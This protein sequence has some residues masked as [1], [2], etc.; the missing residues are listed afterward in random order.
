VAPCAI[1]KSALAPIAD[2]T[3]P[4]TQVRKVP[5]NR[6]AAFVIARNTTLIE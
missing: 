4:A 6:L 5:N 3:D 2:M 1:A